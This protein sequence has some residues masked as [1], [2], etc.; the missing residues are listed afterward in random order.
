[1]T[2]KKWTVSIEVAQVWIDDGFDLTADQL[3]AAIRAQMLG[4]ADAREIRVEVLDVVDVAAPLA[5]PDAEDEAFGEEDPPGDEAP[6]FTFEM[7]SAVGPRLLVDIDGDVE[8]FAIIDAIPKG[9]DVDWTS[10]VK[11]QFNQW[12]YPLVRSNAA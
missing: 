12:S 7:D 3:M 11:T 5:D 4:F 2:G 6:P 9:W 10:G 1:M 8:V